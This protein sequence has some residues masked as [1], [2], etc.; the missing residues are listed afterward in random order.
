MRRD[1][2]LVALDPTVRVL[3][4]RR[5]ERRLADQQRVA[6]RRDGQR[7]TAADR[8]DGQTDE[9]QRRTVRQAPSG[10]SDINTSLLQFFPAVK[11]L[12]FASIKFQTILYTQ[13]GQLD[14]CRRC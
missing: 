2:V 8:E 3:Q 13:L 4:A 6:D 14:H 1:V 7:V 12:K 10:S 5:L 11:Y 9:R